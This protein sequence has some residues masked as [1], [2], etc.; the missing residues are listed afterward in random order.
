M[1]K[2]SFIT[3]FSHGVFLLLCLLSLSSLYTHTMWRDEYQAWLI[4][5]T[6]DSIASIFSNLKHEGHPSLWYICLYLLQGV[7]PDVAS[8]KILHGCI[9]LGNILL[10]YLMTPFNRTQRLLICGSTALSYHYFILSRSYS[11]GI[12]FLFLYCTFHRLPGSSL[13][14]Y[15][16][17]LCLGLA[18]NAIIYTCFLSITMSV[19]FATTLLKERPRKELLALLPALLG[20]VVCIYTVIPHAET[21]MPLTL[22]HRSGLEQPYW[23]FNPSSLLT[24]IQESTFLHH[25]LELAPSRIWHLIMDVFWS[26][27]ALPHTQNAPPVVLVVSSLFGLFLL[28]YWLFKSWHPPIYVFALYMLLSA[29]FYIFV[30]QGYY[31]H[32]LMTYV[33]FIVTLWLSDSV[34]SGRASTYFSCLLIFPAL[35]GL[36]MHYVSFSSSYSSLPR[37]QQSL[38]QR[39]SQEELEQALL[40]AIPTMNASGLAA[41]FKIPLYNPLVDRMQWYRYYNAETMTALGN[42]ERAVQNILHKLT[43][44]NKTALLVTNFNAKEDA[45]FSRCLLLHELSTPPT[46]TAEISYFTGVTERFWLYQIHPMP[47]CL[48]DPGHLITNPAERHY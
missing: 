25:A 37:I 33:A 45:L 46:T 7:S 31:R 17:G 20:I 26:P 5:F 36:M 1:N 16:K 24:E 38:K 47:E 43:S 3:K 6:S 39:Y 34:K 8:M 11:I 22:D 41:Y 42:H 48:Q 18:A 30:F 4:S 13:R 21:S 35:T 27:F 29:T 12:L 28:T 9:A 15:G 14:S 40:I 44:N 23:F 2:P 19:H 32:H 10:V